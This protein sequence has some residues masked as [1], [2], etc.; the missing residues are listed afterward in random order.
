MYL[1]A[2]RLG[3]MAQCLRELDLMRE[4]DRRS[5]LVQ[6]RDRCAVDI[7]RVFRGLLGKRILWERMK[8]KV[9]PA[10]PDIPLFSLPPLFLSPP[11]P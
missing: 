9:W 5:F 2:C 6:Y 7:Q 3:E 11:S 10:Y 8:N 1:I 4:E